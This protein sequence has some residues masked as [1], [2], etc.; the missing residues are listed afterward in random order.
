MITDNN[1]NDFDDSDSDMKVDNGNE[2]IMVE[3]NGDDN[4]K[5]SVEIRLN[6][7]PASSQSK[8]ALYR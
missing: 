1:V 4:N 2:M 8:S 5:K 3:G 6:D 7:T